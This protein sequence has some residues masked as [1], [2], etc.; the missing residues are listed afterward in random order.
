[1][2]NP[3]YIGSSLMLIGVLVF[4]ADVLMLATGQSESPRTT[5]V[6][7]TLS[8]VLF[9]AGILMLSWSF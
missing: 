6:A 1:M 4:L 9:L 8:G 5:G 2:F 3:I 7:M